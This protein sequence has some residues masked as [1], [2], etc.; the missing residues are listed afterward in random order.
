MP[1]VVDKYAIGVLGS[2][3][4]VDGY[5]LLL[6][7]T[8]QLM[9]LLSRLCSHV[10]VVRW[11]EELIVSLLLVRDTLLELEQLLEGR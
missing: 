5:L 11:G 7:L 10:D 8:W 1:F 2:V 4:R 3:V 6:M 9:Q